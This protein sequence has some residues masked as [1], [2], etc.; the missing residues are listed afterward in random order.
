ML[1]FYILIVVVPFSNKALLFD[2]VHSNWDFVCEKWGS[3][4]PR[5]SSCDRGLCF[6]DKATLCCTCSEVQN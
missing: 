4:S 6:A 2:N 5:K 3:L 1:K